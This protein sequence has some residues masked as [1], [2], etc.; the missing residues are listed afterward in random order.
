M[1]TVVSVWLAL[2]LA[3]AAGLKARRSAQAAGALET[4]GL[5]DVRAQRFTV[6]A[7]VSV[8]LALASALAAGLRWAPVAVAALFLTFAAGQLAALLAGRGGRPCACF[9]SASRLGWSSPV[10]GGALALAAGALALGWLPSSPAGYDR[11]LT[12]GLSLCVVAIAA[13]CAA[14]LALAREVGVLRLGASGRGALEIPEEGPRVG[15]SEAWASAIEIAPGALLRVAIFT[16]EACPLCAQVTP[17]VEHVAADPLLAVR[18][19]DELVDTAVWAQAGVPGSPYAV[20]LSAAGVALAK[21]TF[22]S[23]AQLESVLA[24]ARFRERGLSLA[25]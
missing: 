13:L 14:L 9:G 10:R 7:L 18:I 24:T 15:S 22:N 16:S 21:G 1:T 17:A 2:L 4:Y 19:F 11:W 5:V 20:V 25:A 23:L 6:W 3:A 8:E 12:V